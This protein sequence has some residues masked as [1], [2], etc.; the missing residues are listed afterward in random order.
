MQIAFC[1]DDLSSVPVGRKEKRKT[2]IKVCCKQIKR[3]RKWHKSIKKKNQSI[4]S[5]LVFVL[6]FMFIFLFVTVFVC[7]FIYV[8][9]FVGANQP[10]VLPRTGLTP[11]TTYTGVDLKTDG[12]P[13][14][15]SYLKV[16]KISW[17]FLE[18]PLPDSRYIQ[19]VQLWFN[20]SPAQTLTSRQ[21]W[22]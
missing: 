16:I 17:L 4:L 18:F 6:A 22:E 2:K 14:K 1:P 9:I 21:I 3:E 20:P 11:P 5:V 13:R 8:F 15:G 12:F 7:V 19:F 10:V